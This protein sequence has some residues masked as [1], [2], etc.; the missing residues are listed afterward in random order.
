MKKTLLTLVC[1]MF[2]LGVAQAA[3]VT[4]AWD[5]NTDASVLGY[6]LYYGT[7]TRSYGTPVDVGK[8]TQYT[9]SNIAEGVN[10]FFAV[11][12]YSATQESAYSVELPCWTLIP[13]VTG[14]GTISP[15]TTVVVSNITP[16]TFTITPSSGYLI[17]DLK[18]DNVS[19][20][21]LTSY[22]FSSPTTSHTIKAIFDVI[23]IPTM[24]NG[25]KI[26]G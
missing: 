15:N 22:T 17:K 16:K 11:T 2:L 9:L 4:L 26:I 10:V 20:T 25:L 1:F 18:I 23:P 12:A 6:K 8:V 19:I 21:P 14:S 13:S 7:S 3:Q 5:A 24:V